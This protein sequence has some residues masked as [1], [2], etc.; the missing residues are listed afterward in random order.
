VNVEVRQAW[1]R[2]DEAL[3][4][5][6]VY[7]DQILPA[8]RRQI[9]AAEAG[10]TSGRN[11]FSDIMSAQRQLR[12]FEQAYAEALANTWR[13]RAAITRAAGTAS[14]QPAEGGVR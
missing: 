6:A 8:A 14:G 5:I 11:S 10:Y 1:V 7:R 3:A 13:R 4:Q 12:R 2:F 9:E